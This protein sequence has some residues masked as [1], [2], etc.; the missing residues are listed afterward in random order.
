MKRYRIAHTTGFK[1]SG[2]VI[3]SYNEARMLPAREPNQLVLRGA[4]TFRQVQQVM[5]MP[6]ISAPELCF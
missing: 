4:S 2:L 1:Y 6:T 3:T 5:N